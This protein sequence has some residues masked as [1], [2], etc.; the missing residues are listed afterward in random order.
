MVKKKSSFKDPKF[1]LDENSDMSFHT[2][3]FNNLKQEDS[4]IHSSPAPC[5][6][7]SM[8]KYINPLKFDP[9]EQIFGLNYDETNE[10]IPNNHITFDEATENQ[11]KRSNSQYRK[12]QTGKDFKDNSFNRT[13]KVART[14]TGGTST[15]RDMEDILNRINSNNQT[16]QNLNDDKKTLMHEYASG[17]SFFKYMILGLKLIWL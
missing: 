4:D 9:N 3:N 1:L 6:K 15:N 11:K 16:Q 2:S 7:L 17:G 10:N 5:Q 8:S 12:I 13:Q 14:V